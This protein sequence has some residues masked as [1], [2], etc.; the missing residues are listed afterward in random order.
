MTNERQNDLLVPTCEPT[1][2]LEQFLEL[3]AAHFG[4]QPHEAGLPGDER[5]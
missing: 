2:A 5:D 1:D 3:S 4:L